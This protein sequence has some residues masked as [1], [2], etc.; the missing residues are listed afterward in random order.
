MS[1]KPDETIEQTRARANKIWHDELVQQE[2]YD[3]ILM[4]AL[5]SSKFPEKERK[6]IIE[7]MR[8]E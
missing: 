3:R 5:M 2:E 8:K 7:R 4:K 1:A 6:K